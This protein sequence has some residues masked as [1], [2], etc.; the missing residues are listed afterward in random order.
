MVGT[1]RG[2]RAHRLVAAYPASWRA[3]YEPEMLAILDERPPGWRDAVDLLR[4]ALDAHLHPATRSRVPAVAALT[5]GAAW[6]V[7]AAAALAEPV[8]ADWPGYV[9]WMLPIALVGA[10]AGLVA[11]LG[12]ALR[13]G[14]DPGRSGRIAIALVVVGHGIWA[15]TLAVAILGGPYGA[16]TG[17]AGSAAAVG[18]AAVGLVLVRAGPAHAGVALVVAA[19]ALVLPPP[20]SWVGGAVTWT[21][22]GLWLVAERAGLVGGGLDAPTD[23]WQRS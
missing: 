15:A 4:G 8:P 10:V 11:T 2:R 7:V 13:L 16:V 21:L 6:T 22:L 12:L 17:A 18:I 9:G 3:R 14:D 1:R 23:P 20:A 19:G 5:A